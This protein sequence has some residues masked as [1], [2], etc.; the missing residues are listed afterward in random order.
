VRI[1]KRQA[2]SF[3]IIAGMAGA[4]LFL[5]AITF[6]GNLLSPSRLTATRSHV[7]PLLGHAIW[8][9][10]LG[11][12]ATGLRPL[13]PFGVA[14]MMSCH[15]LAERFDDRSERDR[16]H[17]ECMKLMPA[18]QGAAYLSSVQM[19]SDGVWQTPRVPFIQI[20]MVNQVTNTWTREQLIDTL[21]ERAEFGSMFHGAEPAARGLFNRPAAELTP[22]QA[23]L[24]AA[25]LG[26]T[27]IDPW[28]APA[29]AAQQRR[30]ILE[31]MRDDGA[32]DDATVQSA[33]LAELGLAAPPPNHKGCAE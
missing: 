12:R 9:R 14:R 10:A 19:R 20:A 1:D 24:L 2:F 31:R 11:G 4:F 16:Q 5:P 33:N 7:P 29:Q 3:V 26:D 32:I 22:S 8:A 23:A 27:R 13:E 30:R 21:A 6:L 15:L 25:M 17:D 28:C 18:V